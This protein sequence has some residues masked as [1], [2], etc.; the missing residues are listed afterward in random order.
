MKHVSLAIALTVLILA[1]W[2][3]VSYPDQSRVFSDMIGSAGSELAAAILAHAPVTIADLRSDYT[4]SPLPGASKV[5]VLIVPG[6]EPD[7]GGA[8]Y[9]DLKERDLTVELAQD[10][11]SIFDGDLHYQTFMTRNGQAWYPAFASYFKQDWSDIVAW[12]NAAGKQMSH[13]IAV[14]STT[15]PAIPMMHNNVPE[16]V[17]LRL[18]GIT[19]WAN[20]NNIGITI[21]IHFNDDPVHAA[22]E[23]GK[24]S[25]F[26]IYVPAELYGNSTTTRALAA[27]VYKRL[28]E[29]NPVSD[30]PAESTGIVNEPDLIAIGANDTAASASMLIEYSYIYEQQL[31]DPAI[32]SIFL[33]ELAYETYLG[34]QDFFEPSKAAAQALTYDS[35]VFPHSWAGPVVGKNA[36]S[37][38]VFALQTAL[39]N[40]G[41]YPPSGMS[42]N[43]CPRTGK[44]GAC[45]TSAIK[46]FQ[47]KY[48]ITGD[49]KG[50]AG[51]ETIYKLDQL[52][53]AKQPQAL[54]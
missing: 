9:R 19:K 21:H 33:K 26:A 49:I 13:L 24:F 29:Y 20:E 51:P 12:E 4:P 40:D 36:S 3:A 2:F 31:Q 45:T 15:E 47:D 14:G 41:E 6:H 11:R 37:T 25:G 43:D 32:R 38:E 34:L 53:S 23:P 54:N 28:A 22:G 18:Y 52:Y 35:L 10:L 44:I 46:A 5:R 48:G 16:N 1:P 27:A 8:E 42:M 30:L 39:I 7:Y 17:A 50:V